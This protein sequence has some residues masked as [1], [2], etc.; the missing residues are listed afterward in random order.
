MAQSDEK[1]LARATFRVDMRA[2][3]VGVGLEICQHKE[4]VSV[5]QVICERTK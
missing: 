1:R 5:E 2:H 3:W 4:R